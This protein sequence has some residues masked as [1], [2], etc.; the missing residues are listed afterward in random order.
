LEERARL[1]HEQWRQLRKLEMELHCIHDHV[2]YAVLC[3][4]CQGKTAPRQDGRRLHQSEVIDEWLKAKKISAVV[5]EKIHQRVKR[6]DEGKREIV[7]STSRIMLKTAAGLGAA[8]AAG[9]L[10]WEVTKAGPRII[11]L[12]RQLVQSVK[13]GGGA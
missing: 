3:P 2:P 7:F 10:A 9:M 13:K 5:V 11:F 1:T 4:V 6:S 8:L 12:V